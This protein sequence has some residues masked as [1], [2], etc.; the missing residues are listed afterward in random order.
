[1][2]RDRIETIICR[3]RAMWS[4]TIPGRRGGGRGVK[5]GKDINEDMNANQ[6]EKKVAEGPKKRM[7][8]LGEG[9]ERMKQNKESQGCLFSS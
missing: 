6:K 2:P 7:R 8:V 9:E 3:Q 5:R 4:E 1:M